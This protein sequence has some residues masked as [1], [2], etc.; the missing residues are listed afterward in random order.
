MAKATLM[1]LPQTEITVD[2]TTYT[3]NAMT[4]TAALEAQMELME[5][6]GVPSIKLI[7]KLICGNVS[8]DNKD[9]NDK[10][11]DIIFARRTGHLYSLANEIIK[12]NMPDLF[13]E[14]GTD[15]E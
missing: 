8:V 11:F 10:S 7:K 1:V 15:E 13:T 6:G 9:I 14:S 3:V 4:A 5:S 12:W 2:E